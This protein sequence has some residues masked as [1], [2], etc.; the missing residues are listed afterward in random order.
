MTNIIIA[1]S[2]NFLDYILLE[3]TLDKYISNQENVTII[4][5]AA[6]GADLLGEKYAENHNIPI[7]RCPADW[8]R[9]RQGAGIKRNEDMAKLS[10]QN[11]SSGVLFAFWDGK[12]HGT[13]QMINIAKRYDLEI[14]IIHY[15]K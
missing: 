10:V 8:K 7:I 1:G 11:N 3:K 15:L 9:Y 12:S 6:K 13:K 2:R 4:S 5:G 14:N